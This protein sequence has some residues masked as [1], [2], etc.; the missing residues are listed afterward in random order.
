MKNRSLPLLIAAIVTAAA[1][2]WIVVSQVRAADAAQQ[3][4]IAELN[5]RSSE[6]KMFATYVLKQL[7]ASDEIWDDADAARQRAYV[8]GHVLRAV[9]RA[10]GQ[11]RESVELLNREE[12][13]VDQIEGFAIDAGAEDAELLDRFSDRF[14]ANSVAP[15]RQHLADALRAIHDET[16]SWT[17]AMRDT[18]ARDVREDFASAQAAKARSASA[19]AKLSSDWTA[20]VAHLRAESDDTT[21]AL[22]KAS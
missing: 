10:G 3:R 22:S 13:L 21:R 1:I 5:D 11:A 20:V 17:R 14:G 12:A 7:S 2:G 6:E 8:T 4:R 15:A 16:Q 18:S 9:A 19:R